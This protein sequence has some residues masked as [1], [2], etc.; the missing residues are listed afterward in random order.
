M[1]GT[2]PQGPRLLRNRLPRRRRDHSFSK[3]STGSK[4]ARCSAARTAACSEVTTRRPSRA[5]NWRAACLSAASN[6]SETPR[7]PS[8]STNT[9]CNRPVRSSSSLRRRSDRGGQTRILPHDE[10]VGTRIDPALGQHGAE[11]P[12]PVGER[13]RPTSA[14]CPPGAG[15]SRAGSRRAATPRG[16]TS[17]GQG[18]SRS[19][20]CETL[21]S[22]TLAIGP[23]RREPS[24]SRSS[25]SVRAASASAGATCPS[26]ARWRARM[27]GV[28]SSASRAGSGRRARDVPEGS[29]RDAE[30]GC[31]EDA[32]V[33]GSATINR[34]RSADLPRP[35]PSPRPGRPVIPPGRRRPHPPVAARQVPDPRIALGRDGY[36][37]GGVSDERIEVMPCCRTRGAADDHETGM[38]PPD[39][40]PYGI[41]RLHDSAVGRPR[42]EAGECRCHRR[43][44]LPPG[45]PRTSGGQASSRD[46]DAFERSPR[47]HHAPH[48][49]VGSSTL[50]SAKTARPRCGLLLSQI[51]RLVPDAHGPQRGQ[52]DPTP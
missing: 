21:P 48:P 32:A 10:H 49:R 31:T 37:A 27:P 34:H 47:G 1:F 15:S 24:T 52:A 50:T 16:Q 30:S 4:P 19:S 25:P 35:L 20:A 42:Q 43:T 41:G 39:R 18:G 14:Q 13:A 28:R 33:R 9:W 12:I 36:G 29:H 11:R 17:M 3:P 2:R 7:A 5:A 22:A 23:S 51:P 26:S 40:L 46:C 45:S 6:G 38:A 44:R 8:R